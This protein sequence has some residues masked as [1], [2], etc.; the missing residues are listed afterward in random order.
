[1]TYIIIMEKG[2]FSGFFE[3]LDEAKAAAVSCFPEYGN[4]ISCYAIN[5]FRCLTLIEK[6]STKMRREAAHL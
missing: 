4:I 2:H 6:A 3:T 5:V 1:M